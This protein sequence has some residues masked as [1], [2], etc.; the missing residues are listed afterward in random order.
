MTDLVGAICDNVPENAVH[1]AKLRRRGCLVKKQGL[2]QPNVVVDLDKSELPGDQLRADFLLITNEDGGWVVALELKKGDP[3]I[4]HVT[5]QLQ[6]TA[7]LVEKWI[8][9]EKIEKFYAVFASGRISKR[10]RRKLRHPR[11]CV[12]FRQR[13]IQIK[14]MTCGDQLMKYL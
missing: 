7:R 11:R 1:I 5:R 9:A 4:D 6:A 13:R 3:K 2:P 10:Q 14:W 8:P 12:M